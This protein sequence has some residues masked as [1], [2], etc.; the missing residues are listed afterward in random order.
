MVL[1]EFFNSKKVVD[2][3]F[4]N[5]E[6]AITAAY[7]ADKDFN[8]LRVNKNFRNFF[9]ALGNLQGV[10]FPEVLKALGVPSD[11]QG[12]FIKTIEE[13][14]R[15]LLPRLEIEQNGEVRVYSLLSTTTNSPDFSFLQGIQGQFV[16]R[17]TEDNLRKEKEKLIKEQLRNQELIKQK[18]ERLEEISK[19]LASYLSPQVYN[20]IF[21]NSGENAKKHKRKNLT[22]FVSDIVRFTDLSDT[23]EPELLAKLVNNYLSEMTNIAIEFGGTID[24]FIGDAVMVFFGDPESDGD[25]QDALNCAKMALRMQQRVFELQD[26]WKNLGIGEEIQVRMGISTGYCTVGDFGSQQRL[27][28]TAFGSPVNLAA[29]LESLASPSEIVVSEQTFELISGDI[30]CIPYQTVTPKG[31]SRPIN[32]YVVSK[33]G[34]SDRTQQPSKYKKLGNRVSIDIFDTSDINAAIMELKEIEQEF[35]KLLKNTDSSATD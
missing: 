31:F 13:N 15:V 24:K 11:V 1:E 29:R 23:L 32:T 28:Y 20:S 8:V 26:Y 25:H 9:P 6:N 33:D 10:H 35:E 7:F 27:D 5:F 12:E 3:S 4:F 18:S 17:T 30:N 34:L 19:R 21:E 16:D 2:L 22:V 14:G